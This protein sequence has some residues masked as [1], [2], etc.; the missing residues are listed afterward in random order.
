MTNAS[1]KLRIDNQRGF[2]LVEMM[3]AMMIGIIILGGIMTMYTNTRD[4]QRH[5]DLLVFQ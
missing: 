5:Q 3:I 1:Y 4:A 2:S